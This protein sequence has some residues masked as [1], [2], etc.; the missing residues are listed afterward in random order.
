[1]NVYVNVYESMRRSYLS[2][3]SFLADGL[4][5]RAMTTK[6]YRRFCREG[7][8][9]KIAY[10]PSRDVARMIE[11]ER[12]EKFP[13]GYPRT[14]DRWLWVNSGR[15]QEYHRDVIVDYRCQE[16]NGF[17]LIINFPGFNADPAPVTWL[18]I[19]TGA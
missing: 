13:D 5:D 1:M 6:T 18:F 17:S 11:E 12:Q 14:E 10:R 16:C 2:C 4:R 3:S 19:K 9:F 15:E 8:R 7:R